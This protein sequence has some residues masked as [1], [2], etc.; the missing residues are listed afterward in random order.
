[1]PAASCTLP[2]N[3]PGLLDEPEG[4][5]AALALA[6]GAGAGMTHPFLAALAAALARS[7]VATLR[8]QFPYLERGPGRPDP[9]AVLVRRVR[10]AVECARR[11]GGRPLFAGGKSLGGRMTS[12]AQAE[13]PLPGVSGLVLFGFPLHPAGE[14][15]TA[16]AAH[17]D[18]VALPMLFLQG[19]RDTLAQ[20]DLVRQVAGRL[21]PRAT[22]HVVEGADHAFQVLKRSRRT[23]EEVVQE[24]AAATADW[25]RAVLAGR[26]RA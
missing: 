16:R 21:G 19:T 23:G 1:M 20:L 2:D 5:F 17:L 22:V 8:Y 25:M 12:M 3:S 9:P 6:P 13:Q 15:G 26:G 18:R 4:A 7:G 24:L 11:G 10:A 14:P